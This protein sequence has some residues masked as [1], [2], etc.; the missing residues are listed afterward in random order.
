[1]PTID[2]NKTLSP[3]QFYSAFDTL[4]GIDAKKDLICVNLNSKI[5]KTKR[6]VELILSYLFKNTKPNNSDIKTAAENIKK[7]TEKNTVNLKVAAGSQNDLNRLKFKK[8]A[9]NIYNLSERYLQKHNSST[10]TDQEVQ[11]YRNLSNAYVVLRDL[12]NSNLAP[13]SSE[14]LLF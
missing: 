3:D 12:L 4:S 14:R 2:F 7:F 10:S 11:T 13:N 1:M 8:L 9:L 5:S 6:L